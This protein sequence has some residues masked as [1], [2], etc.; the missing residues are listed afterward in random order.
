MSKDEFYIGE[1]PEKESIDLDEAIESEDADGN[2]EAEDFFGGDGDVSFADEL[3]N[4]LPTPENTDKIKK[5][6][7]S[8]CV[9]LITAFTTCLAMLFIYTLLIL[10]NIKPSAVISYVNGNS[11]SAQTEALTEIGQISEKISPAIASI[12]GKTDYR[13][14]FGISSQSFSG[15]GIVISENGYILTNYSLVGGSGNVMAKVGQ[16]TYTAQIVGSDATKD[17]AILK[18]EAEGLTAATLENSDSVKTGDSVIAMANVLG[19]E[20]GVSV[21][22]GIVCGVNKGVPLSNG[23]TI[24]LLQTDACAGKSCAG[25]CLLNEKGNVI[26]MFTAAIS[27]DS[28]KIG[29]AIPSSDIMTVSESIINTGAAPSGL[30]IGI[31]GNDAEHGV[32]VETVNDNS[33]AKKA[34]V[35]VGDLILKADGNIVKSVSE[36]NKIRD[37]HKKGDTLVLTIYRNGEIIDINVIL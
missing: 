33:P 22:S 1:E 32:T 13:S 20:I 4:Y 37:T 2:T 7:P 6:F 19:E 5:P 14:F 35:K 34:G 23:I 8:W 15:S 25:G 28:D 3:E 31:K 24:N 21:T 30:I 36:I 11:G 26:G 18:I 12:S 29:L 27:V 10:P 16:T 9:A 17:I